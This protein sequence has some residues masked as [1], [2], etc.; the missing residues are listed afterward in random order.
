MTPSMTLTEALELARR[1]R[2]DL[3]VL[4]RAIGIGGGAYALIV[5]WPRDTPWLYQWWLY[6][7]S[8]EP[9][10]RAEVARMAKVGTP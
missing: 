7:P 9:E 2:E 6:G 4:C 1:L 5:K 10:V 8:D 3:D